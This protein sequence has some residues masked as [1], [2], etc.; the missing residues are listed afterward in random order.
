MQIPIILAVLIAA[1]AHVPGLAAQEMVSRPSLDSVRSDTAPTLDGDVLND[2]AWSN[3]APTTDFTQKT[4]DQGQ[5]ASERTEVYVSY[6][7]DTLYFGVV[8]YDRDP[9]G[10]IVADSRRDSPL[11]E[12]DSFQIILDTY[13]D[14]LTGFVFGTNPAG[15]EYDGQVTREGEGGVFSDGGFNKNWDGVWEVRTTTS[16]LGWTA[17][18]AIPFRTIRYPSGDNQSWSL[19]M[20]RNI[21][22]RNEQSF[23]APVPVQF[24]LYRLALAGTLSGLTVPSQRNFKLMPFVV[25]STVDSEGA[26]V[27][28]DLD[29]GI[30]LKYSITP[31]LTLDATV[32]TDFAHVEADELQVNLDRFNLFYPEKRPFFLENAGS[33]SVGVPQEVELFFSRR[34]GI[35]PSGEIIPITAGARV[36][37]KAAGRYNVGALYMRTEGIDGVN[38]ENDFA[39]V[40]V[41]RDFPNR[42][43]FGG[44]IVSREGRGGV[45]SENDFNRTYGIDGRWG[46]GE[47]GLV[48]GFVAQTET[49]GVEGDEYAYR[50]GGS[51]DSA[52]WS[53]STNYTEVADDFNPEVGFL[54]R[55]GYRKPDA[56]ILH[57]IR[58]KDFWG[59]LE[60]RPH[61]SYRGY[62]DFEGFQETGYLHVDTHWEWRSAYELHTGVNFTREGVKDAFEIYPD[63]IVPPG[64]YDHSEAQIVF[65][66]DQGAPVAFNIRTVI[67][68]F[69]GGD[70]ISA[71]PAFRFRLGETF[72]TELS[73]STNDIDLPGGAFRTNL[74]R[75]RLSY[76]FSTLISLQALVQYNDRDDLWAA[77]LRFAWLRSANTGLHV[78]Y[79]EVEDIQG[80][81]IVIPNRSL[82]VKY[83]YLFDVLK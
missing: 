44:I 79:N 81:G 43:S 2:P 5:P 73:W 56:F 74:G 82:V 26:G 35:G 80:T 83:S 46:I 40:R 21:R 50:L 72:N 45:D 57:R 59:L 71:T 31:S 62:W 64:T 22:R 76:S 42:S 41:S 7:A 70:R 58:P 32:N 17:E 9:S 29:F 47:Y 65:M 66:T 12:T 10:I 37:G 20:Q 8:C 15:I 23:W 60:I 61:V 16:E 11:D 6:T 75:L 14:E 38:N 25:G 78:V 28:R 54:S 19:N 63:V 1:F 18:F 24:S 33:F 53:F 3:V 27:E 13:R 69:F 39:V 51:Y 67:G 68:G 48:Q 55:R 34:I 36:S 52:K 4:P 77:N 30:D 49:P